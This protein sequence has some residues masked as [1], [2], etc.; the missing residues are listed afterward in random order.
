MLYVL[1]HIYRTYAIHPNKTDSKGTLE[2]E[3]KT[4]TY[5]F[6]I[7]KVDKN[8]DTKDMAGAASRRAN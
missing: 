8:D 1:R 7:H 2:D 3:V 5:G 6:N 4:Y